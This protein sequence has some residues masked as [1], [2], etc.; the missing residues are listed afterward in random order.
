MEG[1]IA[2]IECTLALGR[3]SGTNFAN[4]SG[5]GF[6]IMKSSGESL[7][8]HTGWYNWR[9]V[10]SKAQL[11]RWHIHV[12]SWGNGGGHHRVCID[13][14]LFW[15]NSLKCTGTENY[16]VKVIFLTAFVWVWGSQK[17]NNLLIGGEVLQP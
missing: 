11:G 10:H 14:C 9:R 4:L 13:Q 16:W 5:G 7:A 12:A 2:R 8:G 6:R 17:L 1:C 3:A 15:T